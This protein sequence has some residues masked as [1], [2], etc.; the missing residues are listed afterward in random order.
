M[1]GEA[2]NEV[3]ATLLR[4]NV[5][6]CSCGCGL[7]LGDGAVGSSVAAGTD[8]GGTMDETV[9]DADLACG[10]NTEALPAGGSWGGEQYYEVV[11][12]CGCHT[13]GEQ[14]ESQACLFD[15]Y[16]DGFLG[17][18]DPPFHLPEAWL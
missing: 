9:S 1:S 13:C 6:Y 5:L 7:V 11:S 8:E 2:D 10:R 4:G 3:D 18:M 15:L 12:W 16:V 14:M 17:H